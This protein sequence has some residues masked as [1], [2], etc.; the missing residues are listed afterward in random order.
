[1]AIRAEL[2]IDSLELSNQTALITFHTFLGQSYSVEY[3]SD[4]APGSWTALPGGNVTG[5]G[6]DHTVADGSAI[7]GRS[8]FYRIEQSN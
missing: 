6:R 2:N 4:L 5:D 3:S 7:S 1:M 8:R